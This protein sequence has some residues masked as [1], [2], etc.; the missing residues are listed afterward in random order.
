M[1]EK[2]KY[3][4]IIYCAR[5]NHSEDRHTRT[6]LTDETA[7]AAP[8]VKDGAPVCKCPRFVHP[9]GG[10]MASLSQ[11]LTMER[12]RAG[13]LPPPFEGDTRPPRR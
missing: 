13:E 7:C 11:R 9:A 8:T 2:K 4:R 6:G 5:C 12:A 3:K 1:T 10:A